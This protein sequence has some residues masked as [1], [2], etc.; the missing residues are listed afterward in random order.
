MTTAPGMFAFVA[1]IA[2]REY[3]R[4]ISPRK[5]FGCARRML[6]GGLSCSAHARRIIARFGVAAAT[7]LMKRRFRRC[8]AAAR[9]L[10]AR[11]LVLDYETPSR[12]E[13]PQSPTASSE[14][15]GCADAVPETCAHAGAE[16]CA[17]A[18]C[19]IPFD[20]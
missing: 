9:V 19:E 8:S 13:N 7:M 18:A 11:Q 5:G 6:R 17:H 20:L 16:G 10:S 15:S 12:K 3:Q 1:D 2:I 4:S 14:S